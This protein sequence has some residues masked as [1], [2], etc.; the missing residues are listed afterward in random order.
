M[1]LFLLFL[2]LTVF[3]FSIHAQEPDKPRYDPFAK[4]QQLLK[5]SAIP[6]KSEN[7]FDKDLKLTATLRAGKNSMVSLQG[8]IVQLGEEIEGYKLIK[9]SDRTAIFA[10]NEQRILLSLDGH[11]QK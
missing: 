11:E 2:V 8:K 4:P 9:V 10:N 6:T 7:L 1:I 5:I 3:P